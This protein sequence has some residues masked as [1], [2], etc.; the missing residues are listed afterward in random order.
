MHLKQQNGNALFFILIAIALLGLLT[1]TMTRSGD[2]TNDT[3][4][5][6]QNQIVASEVLTY[7]KSIENAVQTLLARGCS[8]NE[9][10]FWHDSDGNGTEDASDDYYNTNSPTDHSCHVFDVAGAG[11]TYLDISS[12]INNGLT[13]TLA[14]AS[15]GRTLKDIGDDSRV[16]LYF[17]IR[18]LPNLME[19]FCTAVNKIAG[20]PKT[21]SAP[22]GT[23]DPATTTMFVLQNTPFTGTFITPVVTVFDIPPINGKSTF[24]VGHAVNSTIFL[25]VLH[26][27]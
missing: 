17:S 11:M 12:K 14:T 6:E 4:D 5:Y 3:G 26:A 27:R 2:S 20:V 10:S 9:I 7:A 15:L 25:H 8:E 22:A 19:S 23:F 16:D 18:G 13:F 21:G 24:C 1:V